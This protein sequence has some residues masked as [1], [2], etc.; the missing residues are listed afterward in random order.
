MLVLQKIDFAAMEFGKH[1]RVI[2]LVNCVP[3]DVIL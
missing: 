2:N 1:F 3:I